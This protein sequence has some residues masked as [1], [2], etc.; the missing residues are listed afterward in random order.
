MLAT[1][2][3]RVL[4]FV[5]DLLVAQLFGTTAAAQAFVVAFR[6]PNLLRDLVAEGAITSAFVPVL[7]WYRAKRPPQEFWTLSQALLLRVLVLLC[8]V[9]AAGVLWAPAV[10]RLIAPGFIEDPEKFALTVRLTRL[11]FPFVIFVGLWAYFMGLLNSLQHFT[12]PSLGPAILNVAMVVACLWLVPRMSPGIVGLAYGVMAGALLQVLVQLPVAARLGFR[13][14]WHWRHPGSREVMRLLGPRTVGAAVYQGNV[15]VHTALASLSSIVGEGAVAALYYANRLV[16]LPL[17]LFGTA[18]AQASLPSLTEQATANDMKG[19]RATLISV[20]RMMA[21][22]MLPAS[23][24]LMVLAFPIVAGLFERGAFDHRSTIMT[25]QAIIW[26]STGL[27]AYSMA[28]IFSGAFYALRDTW[29]P[30]RLAIEASVVNILLSVALM[31]GMQIQGLALSAALANSLNA[32]RLVRAME[33]RLGERLWQPLLDP[34]LRMSA[35]SGVMGL[36]A[37]W[38]WAVMP[39]AL[40]VW[41]RL[42]GTIGAGV[43]IYVAACALLRVR[44]ISLVVKW[45]GKLRALPESSSE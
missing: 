23:L 25:S 15:F 41:V 38:L 1:A 34:L 42:V 45:F 14:A 36:G 19:F 26:Y 27:V 22:V 28:K 40:P 6:L 9:G 2:L 43:G 35:A 16:Q 11:L 37:W 24:G 44:E 8:I 17:A 3:S 29:T 30:V 13:W 31:W 4:G 5:R 39:V 20:T 21:F 10:V 7:S 33:R 12:M 18:A 32:W